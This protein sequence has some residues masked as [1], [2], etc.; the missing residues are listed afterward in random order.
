MLPMLYNVAQL[1]KEGIGSSR[2]LEIDGD[3]L[4][5]DENNPGPTRVQGHV[6]LL[7]TVGG[8]L[9]VGR[10]H[11]K[12]IQPCR[13]CLRLTE[14]TV[15]FDVEEEFVPSV[16]VETGATLALAG[17]QAPELV[18]DEYHVLDL[19]EVLRQYVVMAA[20]RHG[21]CRPDCRGLCPKCGRVRDL[22]PCDCESDDV[23]P[24]FAILAQLLGAHSRNQPS[25]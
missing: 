9:A 14:N 18:I 23:D 6:K 19:T 25:D 21:L 4:E 1:L 17:D 22:E 5:L 8:V 2:R 15:S 16:G 3:L 13:R 11:L 24:R 10:V 12:L 7:R 20:T